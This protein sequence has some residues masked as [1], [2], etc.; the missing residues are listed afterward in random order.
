MAD[1]PPVVASLRERARADNKRIILPEVDDPRIQA[2]RNTLVGE[3]LC[4][5]VWVEDPASHDLRPAVADHI[6]A[7]RR[8]KGMTPEGA[9][10][11][12][13]D[14]LHFA[15]GLVALGHADGAVSGAAHSTA[16]VIRAGL[17]CLGAKPAPD[18]GRGL[19]SSAFLMAK[20]DTVYTYADCGVI[21]DPDAAQ[22]VQIAAA[23]ASLH[24]ALTE[25][26][27]RVAFLSFSTLGSADHPH[28]TKVREASA[29]FQQLYPDIPADGELQLDAAVV[30][31]VAE[32]KAPE[33]SVAGQANV[34][35]F[36]D[37]DAGNITYKATERL[38]GFM[39][40]GPLL[41]GFPKPFL[42]LSRGC[43]ANDVVDVAVIAAVLTDS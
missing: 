1:L 42:D 27:P 43:S 5:V 16:S 30:P 41:Q 35:V 40:F 39:A 13:K 15:A 33:S 11:L 25:Q 17:T 31:G 21:P 26:A 29:A 18:G 10:E 4:E 32:R 34:M 7:R 23:S 9:Q 19:V 8:A 22:L 12:A 38:G 14:P 3:G 2:A 6:L 28:V 36:P 37:L 24:Q 20:G